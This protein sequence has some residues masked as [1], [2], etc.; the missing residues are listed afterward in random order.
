MQTFNLAKPLKNLKGQFRPKVNAIP[1]GDGYTQR[2]RKGLNHIEKEW[3]PIFEETAE[4]ADQILA[5]FE[6]HG[7]VDPFLW[8]PPFSDTPIVVVCVEWDE[9]SYSTYKTVTGK[10]VR[11]YR[12]T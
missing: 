5:F 11:E 1:F 6:A 9:D 3:N 12:P 8:T 4:V 10:F 7:G 2:S